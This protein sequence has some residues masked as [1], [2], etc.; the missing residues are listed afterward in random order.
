MDFRGVDSFSIRGGESGMG[1]LGAISRGIGDGE[2]N[3]QRDT[4]IKGVDI[5]SAEYVVEKVDLPGAN[6]FRIR[7]GESEI[8]RLG[9]T[10]PGI[11]EGDRD[12][13]EELQNLR[14]GVTSPAFSGGIGDKVEGLRKMRRKGMV[15][16]ASFWSGRRDGERKLRLGGMSGGREEGGGMPR[17]RRGGTSGFF[18][19]KRD[20]GFGGSFG[21]RRLVGE[22]S[23]S[24]P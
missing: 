22:S 2:G 4:E 24:L 3:E 16:S 14:R 19:W 8:D 9:A 1:R 23:E 18:S 7:G 11:S 21:G 5:F 13:C 20:L 12:E 10:S 15:G 6:S 17:L